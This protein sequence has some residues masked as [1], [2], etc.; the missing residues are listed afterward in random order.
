MLLR[1]KKCTPQS[2]CMELMRLANSGLLSRAKDGRHYLY[3]INERTVPKLRYLSSGKSKR[4]S[5]EYFERVV[6]KC[7]DIV[8]LLIE[9]KDRLELENTRLRRESREAPE[10]KSEDGFL[11]TA[12]T[13]LIVR[14]YERT[15]Q[16]RPPSAESPQQRPFRYRPL[17]LGDLTDVRRVRPVYENGELVKDE[18]GDYL[19]TEEKFLGIWN[20]REFVPVLSQARRA[21][22]KWGNTGPPTPE[23]CKRYDD[24]TLKEKLCELSLDGVALGESRRLIE[25]EI[26]SRRVSVG[27]TV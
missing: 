11:E 18:S 1:G 2:V 20:G 19:R 15:L 6:G 26:A 27:Q 13:E 5:K 14:Q 8:S 9:Q 25:A 22:E 16:S 7:L 4:V 24:R 3:S 17:V 21:L 12:M 23:E 10:T